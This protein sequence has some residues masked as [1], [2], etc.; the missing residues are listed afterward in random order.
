MPHMLNGDRIRSGILRSLYNNIDCIT[1][2]TFCG[3][4]KLVKGIDLR[5]RT[6]QKCLLRVKAKC[7]ILKYGSS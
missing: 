4:N 5:K 6:A 7:R 3:A 2:H 1:R